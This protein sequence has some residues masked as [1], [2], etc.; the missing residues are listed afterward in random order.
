MSAYSFAIQRC[1]FSDMLNHF[2]QIV[3]KKTAL[4]MSYQFRSRALGKRN[5]RT[6][7]RH[8]LNDHHTEWLFPFNRIEQP[9]STT[10]PINLFLHPNWPN[11]AN[12]LTIKLWFNHMLKIVDRLRDMLVNCSSKH[13]WPTARLRRFNSQMRSLFRYKAPQPEKKILRVF[14]SWREQIRWQTM[15]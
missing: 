2:I 6:S 8:S 9:I 10:K 12:L 7:N 4:S 11:I 5:D 14:C 3:N 15:M 13:K 1:K